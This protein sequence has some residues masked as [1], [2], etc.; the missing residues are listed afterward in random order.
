MAAMSAEVLEPR[1]AL[2][3]LR[4]TAR[5]LA[6][7]ADRHREAV[8][9]DAWPPEATSHPA[10]LSEYLVPLWARERN[11]LIDTFSLQARV[12]ASIDSLAAALEGMQSARTAEGAE[13]DFDSREWARIRT[14]AQAVMAGTPNPHDPRGGPGLP[15]REVL[16]SVPPTEDGLRTVVDMVD[17]GGGADADPEVRASDADLSSAVAALGAVYPDV[18]VEEV[19]RRLLFDDRR[20]TWGIHLMGDLPAALRPLVIDG[21]L[22]A[23]ERNRSSWLALLVDYPL[24]EARDHLLRGLLDRSE[25]ART[26]AAVALRR[27]GDPAAADPIER[28]LSNDPPADPK[29]RRTMQRAIEALRRG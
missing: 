17:R 22:E 7:P 27:I 6:R 25:W 24:W 26:L 29:M 19:R 9:A 1:V 8:E 3:N 23:A 21:Y 2:N 12:V 4:N 28:S 16:P 20:L 18:L 11:A 15:S 13:D 5:E 14:L 10:D